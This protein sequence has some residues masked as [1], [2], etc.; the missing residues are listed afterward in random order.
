[1]QTNRKIEE[2]VKV[3]ENIWKKKIEKETDCLQTKS[4]FFY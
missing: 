1:M 3:L 4:N 2:V